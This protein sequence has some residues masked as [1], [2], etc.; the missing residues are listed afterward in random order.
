MGGSA[1]HIPRYQLA[2]GLRKY[3]TKDNVFI[4]NAPGRAM[5][6][7]DARFFVFVLFVEKNKQTAGQYTTRTQCVYSYM[8]P[9]VSICIHIVQ[10]LTRHLDKY[11]KSVKIAFLKTLHN[12]FGD[13]SD[14][15]S[16]V[17]TF[18]RSR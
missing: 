11:Y 10:Y 4:K 2:S 12:D 6:R 17:V 7:P 14:N 1:P 3:S 16:F 15:Q 5:H 9:Y 13:L 8:Y 18:Y